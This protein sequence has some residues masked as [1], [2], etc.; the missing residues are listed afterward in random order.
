LWI[1]GLGLLQLQQ[2][3]W[4][5]PPGYLELFRQLHDRLRPRDALEAL[6]SVA[7][8]ALA[9]A[10]CEELVYRGTLLPALLRW[11]RGPAIV[12]SALAFGLMHF[13]G[14][15]LYRA[16][17]AC[18]V[19]LGLGALRVRSGSLLAPAIAH[20]VLNTLT[21]AV[22]AAGIDGS[23]GDDKLPWMAGAAMLAVGTLL[24]SVAV[25]RTGT[26]AA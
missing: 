13:D 2:L 7:A 20:A 21:F 26:L 5:P 18:A 4:P 12:V 23:G 1:G 22:V 17:F 9:P 10:L 25:R 16:P 14:A 3:V 6:T 15:V 24:T 8:I 19:G 11:G